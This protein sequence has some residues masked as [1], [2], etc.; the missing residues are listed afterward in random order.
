MYTHTHDTAA[1]QSARAEREGAEKSLGA[2]FPSPRD[3][4]APRENA[5][6]G[7]GVVFPSPKDRDFPAPRDLADKEKEKG[8]EKNSFSVPLCLNFCY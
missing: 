7:P 4:P 1:R 5:E 3:F 2:T 8:R 6:K